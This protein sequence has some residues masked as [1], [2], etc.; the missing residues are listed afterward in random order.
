MASDLIEEDDVDTGAEVL[1]IEQTTGMLA[2]YVQHTTAGRPFL[3]FGCLGFPSLA[4]VDFGIELN[5]DATTAEAQE[6]ADLINQRALGLWAMFWDRPLEGRPL[7]E[8][9]ENGLAKLR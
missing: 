6:L 7:Y 2:C 5:P 1:Q 8:L 4:D 9:G 3:S